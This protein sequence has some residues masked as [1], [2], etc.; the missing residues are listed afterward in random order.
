MID[1]ARIRRPAIRRSPKGKRPARACSRPCPTV[2]EREH[3]S[4]RS[5]V[6]L[7]FVAARGGDQTSAASRPTKVVNSAHTRRPSAESQG[8]IARVWAR[9]QMALTT[10]RRSLPCATPGTPRKRVPRARPRSALSSEAAVQSFVRVGAPASIPPGLGPRSR[11]PQAPKPEGAT[12]HEDPSARRPHRGQ[13]HSSGRKDQ[14]G[15]HHPRHREGEARRGQGGRR[16]QR[17]GAE[18]RQ[19]PPARRQGGRQRPLRQVLRHRS[20]ARRR[21]ARDP[22]RGRRPRGR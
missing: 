2:R 19:G 22:P 6:K 15:H 12:H 8:A 20:E 9:E 17:Q 21:R 10:S 1:G 16:G 14:G 18:G 5:A 7:R 4:R 13:A 3:Y 11:G